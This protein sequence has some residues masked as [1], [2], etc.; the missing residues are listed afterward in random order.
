MKVDCRDLGEVVAH[1]DDRE[2][3]LLKRAANHIDTSVEE[4]LTGVLGILFDTI[5]KNIIG[6]ES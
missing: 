3:D 1:L 5:I 6:K 2:I 4:L